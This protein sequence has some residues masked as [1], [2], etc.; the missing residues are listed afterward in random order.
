MVGAALGDEQGADVQT[1][2]AVR[3]AVH[4]VGPGRGA[5]GGHGEVL[6]RVV[7]ADQHIAGIVGLD[8]V[9][10]VGVPD[11]L[12]DAGGGVRARGQGHGDAAAGADRR[13]QLRRDRR[14]LVAQGGLEHLAAA[15]AE[16]IV[17]AAGLRAR[18]MGGGDQNGAADGAGDV[19]GAGRLAGG[20]V[21]R[22]LRE[23]L[24]ADG[25]GLGGLAGGLGTGDVGRGGGE[26]DAAAGTVRACLAVLQHLL[27][28]QRGGEHLAALRAGL[29]RLAGGGGAGHVFADGGRLSAAG[30]EQQEQG[31]EQG[32][33]QSFHG[34]LL[35]SADPRA[36]DTRSSSSGMRQFGKSGSL[37]RARISARGNQRTASTSSRW[38]RRLS[39][40][41]SRR[42]R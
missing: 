23:D 22:R 26:L 15:E 16:L 30:T 25:A 32:K 1:L 11:R 35:S 7:A 37:K 5:C 27:V 40:R 38:S 17:D 31:R 28:A 39:G 24:T 19:L 33:R 3:E 12:V 34:I 2:V 36:A 41:T 42:S 10:I 21:V 9:M 8:I 29:G 13:S 18:L 6:Q 14:G 20:R 4:G